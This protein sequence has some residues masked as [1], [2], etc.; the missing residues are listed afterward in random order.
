MIWVEAMPSAG[1]EVLRNPGNILASA[2]EPANA[3]IE[4]RLGFRGC[5]STSRL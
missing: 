1:F 3:E 5:I 2:S 4:V